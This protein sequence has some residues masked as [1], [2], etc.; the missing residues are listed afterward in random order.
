MLWVDLP[1]VR[2]LVRLLGQLV[3]LVHWL[4]LVSL[5]RMWF[6]LGS[7]HVSVGM[8]DGRFAGPSAHLRVCGELC[9]E[10]AH[11]VGVQGGALLAVFPKN[12]A[13]ELVSVPVLLASVGGLVWHGCL[14]MR[15]R[16]GL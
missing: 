7:V 13:E 6:K 3:Q 14:S 1:G 12:V 10:L 2:V 4:R 8:G 16:Y 5:L 9:W 11:G 15:P